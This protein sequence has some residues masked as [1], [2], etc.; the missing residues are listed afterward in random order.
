MAVSPWLARRV[1]ITIAVGGEAINVTAESPAV[2]EEIRAPLDWGGT[3]YQPWPWRSAPA[4]PLRGGRYYASILV[5]NPLQIAMPIAFTLG[6]LA[7]AVKRSMRREREERV[8]K[9]ERGGREVKAL[10]ERLSAGTKRLGGPNG[11]ER[12]VKALAGGA[13]RGGVEAVTGVEF[14]PSMTLREYLAAASQRLAR[15]GRGGG[16][17]EGVDRAGRAHPLLSSRA[18]GGGGG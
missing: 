18:G 15:G 4:T 5:V 17:V 16:G 10:A 3:G 12:A 1:N 11:G 14:A 13:I 2:V 6:G 8:G 7:V 9:E